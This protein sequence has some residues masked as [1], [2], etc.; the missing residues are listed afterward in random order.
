MVVAMA[1][2]EGEGGER[3]DDGG[4]EDGGGE[5]DKEEVATVRRGGRRVGYEQGG[6]VG[7]K[8][9]ECGG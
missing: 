9:W 7:G 4:R 5:G 6:D 2:E 8:S 1:E 3:E